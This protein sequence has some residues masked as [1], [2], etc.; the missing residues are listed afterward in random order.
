[1][2]GVGGKLQAQISEGLECQAKG[3]GFR[4]KEVIVFWGPL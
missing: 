1:M 4:V 3:L 2:L